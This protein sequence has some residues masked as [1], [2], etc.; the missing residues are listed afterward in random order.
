MTDISKC[1]NAE[2]GPN[3][4]GCSVRNTCYR[5]MAE[6]DELRQSWMMFEPNKGEDC[7]GYLCMADTSPM[8]RCE[9]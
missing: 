4:T 1:A 7:S 6:S 8:R 9:R 3:P 2:G 5:H